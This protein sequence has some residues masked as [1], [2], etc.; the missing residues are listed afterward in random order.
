MAAM[1]HDRPPTGVT[2]RALHGSPI[3]TA[4]RGQPGGAK[5]E[6]PR[7]MSM[8]SSAPAHGGALVDRFVPAG[9]EHAGVLAAARSMTAVTLTSVQQSD[10]FCIATG[11]FSPLTGF[12]GRED[13]ESILDGMRLANGVVWSIPV[14]L[15]VTAD[16]ASGVAE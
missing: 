14:T 3:R 11:V 7:V 15:A 4:H 1:R 10:L 2:L 5:R 13:Y 12:V 16:V 6:Y 9:E 8:L